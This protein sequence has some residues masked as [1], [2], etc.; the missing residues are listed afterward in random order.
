MSSARGGG[1]GSEGGCRSPSCVSRARARL[2]PPP[3]ERGRRA[4]SAAR[5]IPQRG[6]PSAAFWWA[7]SRLACSTRGGPAVLPSEAPPG[8]PPA[9]RAAPPR[10]LRSPLLPAGGTG[11]RLGRPPPPPPPWARFVPSR[12]AGRASGR[13]LPLADR[14]LASGGPASSSEGERGPDARHSRRELRGSLARREERRGRPL[15]RPLSAS[16]EART[17][18]RPTNWEARGSGLGRPCRW[19][20]RLIV[21]REQVWK[22]KA[23]LL[24]PGLRSFAWTPNPIIPHRGPARRR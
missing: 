2:S 1:P 16:P 11:G 24:S 21:A 3:E 5:R 18:P 12:D 20:S 19:G 22:N 7:A 10:A 13:R 17:H 9:I 15:T 8:R 14:Y 6:R 4:A 23:Q